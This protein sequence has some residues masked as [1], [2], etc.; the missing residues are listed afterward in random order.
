MTPNP[1]PLEFPVTYWM[2]V[3]I[4]CNFIFLHYYMQHH[5]LQ[6]VTDLSKYNCGKVLKTV[7]SHR[8]Q[9]LHLVF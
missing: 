9:K 5:L 6:S 3:D 8:K 4:F 1:Y 7:P 2:G